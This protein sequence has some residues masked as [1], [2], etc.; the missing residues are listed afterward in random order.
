VKKQYSTVIQTHHISYD[1]EVTV[2]VF[3]GEHFIL[4]LIGRRKRISQGFCEALEV[5]LKTKRSTVKL[6]NKTG[7][8]K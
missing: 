7:V 6:Q 1:P 8:C 4:T 2:R 3:K 5:W